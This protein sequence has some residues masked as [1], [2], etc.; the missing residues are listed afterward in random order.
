MEDEFDDEFDVICNIAQMEG[1]EIDMHKE[2]AK[3][4]ID[5]VLQMVCNLSQIEPEDNSSNYLNSLVAYMSSEVSKQVSWYFDSG[6]DW[7]TTSLNILLTSGDVGNA[8]IRGGGG[9]GGGGWETRKVRNTHNWK[10][11]TM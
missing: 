2:K 10:M 5:D 7:R 8:K 4:C 3:T 9:G 6:C 1:V 11:S